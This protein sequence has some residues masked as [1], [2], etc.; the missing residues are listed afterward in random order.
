[1]M[2]I[3]IV[4]AAVM[5]MQPPPQ[6]TATPLPSLTPIATTTLPSL[7]PTVTPLQ[8]TPVPP[9]SAGRT[10]VAP[11]AMPNIEQ[12]RTPTPTPTR[13][14]TPTPTATPTQF[15]SEPY[16]LRPQDKAKFSINDSIILQWTPVDR[17]RALDD[18]LVQVSTRGEFTDDLICALRTNKQTQITL[19][20]DACSGRLVFNSI[21]Y[22][23]IQVVAPGGDG[24]YVS[25]S[26]A[27]TVRQF[28]WQP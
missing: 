12:T 3:G 17:L 13:T 8:I 7:V 15:F 14:V 21:Y 22:W 2:L 9:T 11:T 26:P 5:L 6:P 23:R 16:V 19:S 1:L 10:L 4:G 27:G 20:S 25:I 18:Y 28:G 24:R